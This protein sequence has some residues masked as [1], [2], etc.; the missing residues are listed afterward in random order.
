MLHRFCLEVYA[1]L[2]KKTAQWET[3]VAFQ[4]MQLPSS[5]ENLPYFTKVSDFLT[6]LSRLYF[7]SF[8]TRNMSR[9]RVFLVEDSWQRLPLLNKHTHDLLTLPEH[10]PPSPTLLDLALFDNATYPGYC[11][12]CNSFSH[13]EPSETWTRRWSFLLQPIKYD[14]LASLKCTE[15]FEDCSYRDGV[16]SLE[17]SDYGTHKTSE[18]TSYTALQLHETRCT[19]L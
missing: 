17:I 14:G 8:L 4:D 13:W 1:I 11:T 10:P 16:V 5:L 15:S 18:K 7:R 6:H 19:P 2:Y 9:L 3:A 12:R